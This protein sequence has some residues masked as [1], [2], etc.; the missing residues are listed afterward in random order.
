[1]RRA[2]WGPLAAG[3]SVLVVAAA[4]GGSPQPSG[5]AQ[6]G[7]AATSCV[8]APRGSFRLPSA[9]GLDYEHPYTMSGEWVGTSW[10]QPGTWSKVRP[11]YQAELD[12]L[13]S[14][15][16]GKVIRLFVALDQ[17]MV[18]DRSSGFVRYDEN[19]LQ[20]LSQAL[21]IADADHLG[22]IAVLFDQEVVSSP[23]NFHFEAL[24]GSHS[25]MRANYLKAVSLFMQ[26]YGTR[27]TVLAWDLFNE[28]YGSLGTEGQLP[29]PPA[30]DPVSPNYRDS[31]VRAWI[32]DL[33]RTAR[34]A[35]PRAWLTVS[36][37]T[38]LYWKEPADTGAY[39]GAVDFYDIHVYDDN[40]SARDWSRLGKPYILGEVGGDPATGLEDQSVNSRVVGFWLGQA[41]KL[42]AAAVL[43]Q[44]AD[45][46]AFT[47]SGGLTPT[48]HAVA[49][50]T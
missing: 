31:I 16:L 44:A 34:C 23:G 21:D 12:Y 29:R 50:A 36:D 41:R 45:H 25:K 6:A 5:G 18:W 2:G 27:P 10:L 24:D 39:S 17:L 32:V 47:L 28:A 3:L 20:N 38:E 43:P 42:G 7:A 8:T 46:Q 26:R 49:A 1:V 19:A 13:T 22:V 9:K 14:H 30:E 37:T 11:R 33:Y 40:P 15:N 4:C 35:A 48:G